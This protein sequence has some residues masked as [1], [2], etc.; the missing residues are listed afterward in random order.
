[1]SM[2]KERI[3]A[4]FGNTPESFSHRLSQTIATLSEKKKEDSVRRYPLRVIVLAAMITMILGAAGTALTMDRGL[5]WW[6]QGRWSMETASDP[7]LVQDIQ[8]HLQSVIPQYSTQSGLAITVEDAAWLD[9]KAY[10]AISIRNERAEYEM[11]PNFNMN[12]DGFDDD[13][14]ENWLWTSKG[15][16]VPEQVMDDPQKTLLL[17]EDYPI[18]AGR[19]DGPILRGAWDVTRREDGAVQLI[20]EI[21]WDEDSGFRESIEAA[22]AVYTDSDGCLPLFMPFA[23]RTFAQ[24]IYGDYVDYGILGFKVKVK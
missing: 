21:D 13:R 12:V 17:F 22:L 16:G 2:N 6:F 15:F 18:H 14:T 3:D 24:D 20:Q 19:A 1:M 23:T 4:A 5:N 9:S 8:T 11:H 7:T 10:I